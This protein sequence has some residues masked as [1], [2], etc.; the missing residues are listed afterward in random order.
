[1][2]IFT[3]A[4]DEYAPS[5]KMRLQKI[6]DN[7]YKVAP[8]TREQYSKLKLAVCPDVLRKMF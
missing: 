7:F 6:L 4:M 3:G 1:M 2:F 8:L 5:E